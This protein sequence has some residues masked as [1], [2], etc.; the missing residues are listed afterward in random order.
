[1]LGFRDKLGADPAGDRGVGQEEKRLGSKE[2]PTE[3]RDVVEVVEAVE[4][5]LLGRP[6]RLV[7]KRGTLGLE[8]ET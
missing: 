5:G 7:R 2:E 8:M 6:E 3:W 1:M 4:T